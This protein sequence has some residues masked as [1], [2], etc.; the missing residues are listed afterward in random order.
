MIKFDFREEDEHNIG[1][2]ERGEFKYIL[3][4]VFIN[5]RFILSKIVTNSIVLHYMYV[6][7][8]NVLPKLEQR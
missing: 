4:N 8:I 7:I 6:I 1:S 2:F 5:K 3:G